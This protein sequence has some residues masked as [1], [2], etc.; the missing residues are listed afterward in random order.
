[1][2]ILRTTI[3]SLVA[4]GLLTACD[5]KSTSQAITVQNNTVT[6]LLPSP[7]ENEHKT[8]WI[9]S[10][11][12]VAKGDIDWSSDNRVGTQ[13]L[14]DYYVKQNKDNLLDLKV[15]TQH[16]ELQIKGQAAYLN[17]S[18]QRVLTDGLYYQ[19]NSQANTPLVITQKNTET[20]QEI[21]NSTDLS[22][23]YHYLQSVIN[24]PFIPAAIPLV[25]NKTITINNFMEMDTVTIKVNDIT[26]NTVELTLEGKSQQGQ[27]YGKTVIDKKTGWINKLALVKEAPVIGRS[28]YNMRTI[29]LMGPSNWSSNSQ[30][31]LITE[32]QIQKEKHYLQPFPI[33]GF[34]KETW[35]KQQEQ[36]LTTKSTTGKLF[37]LNMPDGA[38]QLMLVY[39]NSTGTAANMLGHYQISDLTI[40][41]NELPTSLLPASNLVFNI[42]PE[43]HEINV[44]TY[45][46]AFQ[47]PDVAPI[48]LDTIKT[49]SAHVSFIPNQLETLILPI[50]H[51][52]TNVLYNQ[53]KDFSIEIT[54]TNQAQTY[55]LHWQAK[56]D[57]EFGARFIN[58]ANNALV[59]YIQ[60]DTETWLTPAESRVINSLTKGYENRIKITFTND[61]PIALEIYLL[62][63]G[64]KAAYTNKVS[65]T[66]NQ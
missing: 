44:A 43:T 61:I 54:P 48:K 53:T 21:S 35:Q 4:I 1:M 20:Q 37:N 16:A 47:K 18:L 11:S 60:P 34:N 14:V 28:N 33:F 32:M 38:T 8:Y 49:A 40:N 27:L 22:S 64:T 2:D 65:F 10:Y 55:I 6:T 63:R 51:K 57:I 29:L 45:R 50:T 31:Q 39:N 59:Q 13:L 7:Q 52:G 19:L 46:P 12:I 23:E 36:E 15:T 9:Q 25:K 5:N 41:N 3:I 24:A 42:S 26:E 58:G 66:R 62:K 56:D 30:R 17:Q